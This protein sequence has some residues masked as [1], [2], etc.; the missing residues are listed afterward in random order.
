MS[1]ETLAVRQVSL[2]ADD[3]PG[4]NGGWVHAVWASSVRFRR[5]RRAGL[6]R[7]SKGLDLTHLTRLGV[8][9]VLTSATLIGL[10]P[11]SHAQSAAVGYRFAGSTDLSLF[12]GNYPTIRGF[13]DGSYIAFDGQHLERRSADGT[14]LQTYAT[15]PFPVFASFVELSDDEAFA[16]IGESS[17]GTISE[18]DLA[19]GLQRVLTSLT[20]N[21]DFAFDVVPGLAYVS[22]ATGGFGTNSIWRLDLVSGQ[23]T[24]VITVSGFS[25]PVEVDALGNVFVSVL[26]SGFPP[27]PGSSR[28]VRFDAAQVTSGVLLTEAQGTP[29]SV[30]FDNIASTELDRRTSRLCVMETNTGAS[31][32]ESVAWLLDVQGQ[33]VG[34]VATAP[35]FAGGLEFVDSGFGTEFGAYQPAYTSLRFAYADCFGTGTWHRWNTTG[36]RPE[37]AFDGP[38]LGQVGPATIS[39]V[40]GIPN[41]FASLWAARTQAFQSIPVIEQLGGLHP[42]ALQARASDF[43]RRSTLIALDA[44]GGASVGFTQGPPLEGA[45]LLQ[46]L[47]FDGTG[48]LVTSSSFAVNR[49]LF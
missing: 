47:V 29:H 42:I 36:A 28:I 16:Y 38:G 8:G 25:G 21:F 26:D 43:L 4:P 7:T 49:D 48:A 17:N 45:L 9:L 46:W 35:G 5:R 40:G 34:P 32:N 13:A 33:R 22:A 10:A 3:D 11:L 20:F 18:I 37:A 31:G 19:T 23:T 39:L 14:L 1:Q 24:E 12:C 15:L 41:G 30:G 27:A 44:Q 6:S 2:V